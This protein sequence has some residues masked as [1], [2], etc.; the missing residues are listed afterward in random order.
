[1]GVAQGR[2]RCADAAGAAARAVA[3][4]DPGAAERARSAAGGPVLLS[5]DSSA[6]DTRV[7]ARLALRPVSWLPAVTVSETAVVATE[8]GR[9]S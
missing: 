6:A 2:I 1:M 4:G 7:T 3:R 9:S 5:I 8:P